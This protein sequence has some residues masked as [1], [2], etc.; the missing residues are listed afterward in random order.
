MGPTPLAGC[1]FLGRLRPLPD[2][3]NQV[4]ALFG[5]DESRRGNMLT[6][7]SDLELPAPWFLKPARA[8]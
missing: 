3:V 6:L 2:F 1:L 5:L 7:P 4:P 8:S